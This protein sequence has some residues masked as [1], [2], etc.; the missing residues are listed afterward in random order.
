VK[1]GNGV[2]VRSVEKGSRGEKAGFHAGDVIVKINDQPVHDTSDFSH[3]LRS[4]SGGSAAV[5][6]MRD[7]REQ[8]LTL[9]LPEKKDSGRL[10]EDS[11][12]IPDFTAETELAIQG[13][14]SE[15]AKLGPAMEKMQSELLR[16]SKAE[17]CAQQRLKDQQ[18]QMQQ[19]LKDQQQ[20]MRDQQRRMLD[21]QK[22]WRGFLGAW[23]EI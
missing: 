6:V 22:L 2:L 19:R 1:N 12:D 13:A 20:R 4:S 18:E 10:F 11:F 7:K 3:A 23:A 14:E 8:N 9:S 16:A 5:T 21:R 17:K 15:M